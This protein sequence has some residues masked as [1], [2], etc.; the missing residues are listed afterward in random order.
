MQATNHQSPFPS[1][2]SGHVN[3]A[4][5]GE[6]AQENYHFLIG[7]DLSIEFFSLLTYVHEHS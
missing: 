7:E 6:V 1:T 5:V 2:D 4:F 3:K